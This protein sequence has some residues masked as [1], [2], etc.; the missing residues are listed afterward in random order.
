M[1]KWIAELHTLLYKDIIRRQ[2]VTPFIIFAA[3]LITF[4]VARLIV[5]LLPGFN[6]ANYFSGTYHIHHFF[7]G[8]GLVILSNW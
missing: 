4:G 7:F 2:M 1:V 3:F 8:I 6:I 5:Y